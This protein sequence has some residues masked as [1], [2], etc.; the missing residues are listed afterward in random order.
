MC[1]CVA[2]QGALWLNMT[3][4]GLVWLC[5]AVCGSVW[6][7]VA[8]WLCVTSEGAFVALSGSL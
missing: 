8:M 1:G 7:C 3:L 6:L 5:V 4:C 2:L